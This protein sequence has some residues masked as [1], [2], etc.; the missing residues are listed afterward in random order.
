MKNLLLLLFLSSAT[1]VY[2]EDLRSREMST[3]LDALGQPD[4]KKATIT[5][6]Q[7]KATKLKIVQPRNPDP[8]VPESGKIKDVSNKQSNAYIDIMN[9]GNSQTGNNSRAQESIDRAYRK[10][11]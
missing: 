11:K 5:A 8:K 3:A 10:F 1:V 6:K 4:A 2:G 9:A 7:E